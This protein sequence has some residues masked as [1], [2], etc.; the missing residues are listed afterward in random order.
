MQHQSSVTFTADPFFV[1]LPDLHNFC[2]HQTDGV[3][4]DPTDCAH[5]FECSNGYTYHVP[6]AP[7]TVFNPAISTCDTKNNVPSCQG[8]D[9]SSGDGHAQG[10]QNGK[11][12]RTTPT[13][14]KHVLSFFPGP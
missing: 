12:A 8:H 6:C 4:P 14:G 11:A 7:G 5:F 10:K 9:T 13:P 2:K 1:V 3:H